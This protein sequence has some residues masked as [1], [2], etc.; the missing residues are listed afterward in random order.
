MLDLAS[1][2]TDEPTHPRYRKLHRRLDDGSSP[3]CYQVPKDRFRHAYLDALE[4][5]SGKVQKRFEQSDVQLIKKIEVLLINVANGVMVE[6]IP[7]D[8]GK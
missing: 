3:H 6:C 4:L 2:L 1:T 8:V 7:D 5:A